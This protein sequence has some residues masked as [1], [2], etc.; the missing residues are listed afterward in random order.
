[1][2]SVILA[3]EIRCFDSIFNHLDSLG[4]K[5]LSKQLILGLKSHKTL[6]ARA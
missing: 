4:E 3:L 1:M 6:T 5:Y 2:F